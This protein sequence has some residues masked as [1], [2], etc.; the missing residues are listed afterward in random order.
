M[1]AVSGVDAAKS[2]L[3]YE[4]LTTLQKIVKT[5]KNC[6]NIFFCLRTSAIGEILEE[7]LNRLLWIVG[8]KNFYLTL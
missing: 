4:S 3:L 5:L 7:H 6:D 2:F 1:F 8:A